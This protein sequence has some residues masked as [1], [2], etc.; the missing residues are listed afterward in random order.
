MSRE[1]IFSREKEKDES[2][3]ERRANAVE[4]GQDFIRRTKMQILRELADKDL[5]QPVEVT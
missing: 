2:S 1:H 4:A 3:V 5:A